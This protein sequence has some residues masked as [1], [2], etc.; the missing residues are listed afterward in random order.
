MGALEEGRWEARQPPRPSFSPY[1]AGWWV[2]GV[3]SS[4]CSSSCSKDST[5]RDERLQQIQRSQ[6]RAAPRRVARGSELNGSLSTGSS[7]SYGT[8]KHSREI[9][10]H[11]A[12]GDF[13]PHWWKTDLSSCARARL[14]YTNT[15]PPPQKADFIK[16]S[17]CNPIIYQKEKKNPLSIIYFKN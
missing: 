5:P 3:S 13:Q 10:C 2:L 1:T 8:D 15:S 14:L 16:R 17:N 12:R 9:K 11:C 7:C 6:G 4:P